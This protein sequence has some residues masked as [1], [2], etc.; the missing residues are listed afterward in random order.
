MRHSV[1]VLL[2]SHPQWTVTIYWALAAYGLATL[3][4]VE[5]RTGQSGD[6]RP[7]YLILLGFLLAVEFLN[8]ITFRWE[9]F[10]FAAA[11][12]A[13]CVGFWSFYTVALLAYAIAYGLFGTAEWSFPGVSELA[14]DLMACLFLPYFSVEPRFRFLLLYGSFERPHVSKWPV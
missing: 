6:L 14:V 10:H 13:K 9:R 4:L 5:A 11:V 1:R 7:K 3:T 8:Q 12:T 2:A